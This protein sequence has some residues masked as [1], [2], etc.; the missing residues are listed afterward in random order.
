MTNYVARTFTHDALKPLL[1]VL[2]SLFLT[3]GC[4]TTGGVQTG[5][6]MQT[7][8]GGMPSPGGGTLWA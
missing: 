4:K 8:G 5:G 1:V 7:P 2:V 3:I 6:G